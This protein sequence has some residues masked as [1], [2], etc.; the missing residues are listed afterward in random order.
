MTTKELIMLPGPVNVDHNVLLA[1]GTAM[2]NHR[3]PKFFRLYAEVKEKLR[4]LLN[5]K[6]EVY[7]ITG[8]GT[9]GNEFA[10]ANLVS[11]HEKVVVCSNG[12]FAE[13]LCDTYK[14][15]GAQVVEV[16]S[17]WGKGINLSELKE[18]V[19]GASLVALVFNETSTG[20]LNQVRNV[21][22]IAHKAGALCV[23]DNV[24]GIGNAYE[25]D[26]WGI[27]VTVIATQKG[28]A[29]PPGMAFVAFS[30][31]AR[32]KALKTPKR[33]LYFNLEWYEKSAKENS[34][35]ATPAI[36]IVYA[37]NKALDLI[38]DEGIEKFV[39]RHYLNAEALRRGVEALGLKLFA[40]KELAS[41]TVTAIALDGKA[42]DVVKTM[43]E[44]FGVVVA[45]GMGA[46]R[47]NMIRIGHMGRVD[48][49]D[50][51]STLSALEL[52]L[53][54]NGLLKRPLGSGVN[55]ALEFYAQNS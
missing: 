27:D 15:I 31:K 8:S 9:A 32:E 52:S 24:S 50:I 48:E 5:T 10:A 30:E 22:E 47:D 14:L 17:E 40:E 28:I 12:F 51:I 42:K 1:M 54:I 25:M 4:K 53:K 46:Y 49:K 23:V 39:K 35:P 16:R 41:N 3:G 36:S 18:K 37:L 6:G 34:T 44:K 19:E 38:F 21:A 2:F 7:F 29:A 33:S 20:V 13:R 45:P 55:A 26:P 43:D 11:P